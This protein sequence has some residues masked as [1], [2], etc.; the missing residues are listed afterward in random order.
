[1]KGLI[2]HSAFFKADSKINKLIEVLKNVEGSSIIY[3]RTRKTTKQV[4][5]LLALQNIPA[6]FYNAGLLQEERNAR[7]DA[8]TNNSTRVMVCTNAFGMGIDK[9][10]V[11]TVIHYDVPDCL[12]NYYQEAG[13]AGR[14]GKKAYA[15]LIYHI[16]D[17][18]WMNGL[19]DVRFPSVYNI[20]K[21]YQSL[22]DFLQ[23]PV[24]IGDGNYYDFDL[25]EFAGNFNIDI[26]L[27]INVLKVLEQEGHLTFTE[28]IFLPSQVNF[29]APKMLL[30]DL[31]QSHPALEPV[32]KCL[33]RTYEGIYDNRVSINEKLIAKLTR[34]T[35]DS[36]R[37][38]LQQL[39]ALHIID[40]LPQKE[41]PQI[42]FLLN[43][44]PAEFL[45]IDNKAYQLR[46]QQ[47]EAR[48]NAMLVYMQSQSLCRSKYL[49][50]YFGD[51]DIQDCGIC[52]NCLT[53]K[54]KSL[55]A[56]EFGS[57]RDKIMAGIIKENM[58]VKELL[59]QLTDVDKE[60][61]WQVLE[62][63]QSERKIMIDGIGRVT[64][65]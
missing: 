46:K 55:S 52:D 40:Y 56:K 12:E 14:D 63:L 6:D 53:Q 24:G 49:G 44:A 37:N 38:S 8:W 48:V 59:R 57:I 31:E 42:H 29:I 28:N 30:D 54:N 51:A 36:V 21:V 20:K 5:Q 39:K 60:K 1:L 65:K 15:V 61:F 18:D 25:G 35:I 33:L 32:I 16:E 43:R 9:P 41:T 11:R 62:H 17:V 22:A 23:I 13:R 2:Y 3:C 47:F 7:Q 50:N 4:S 58:P 19:A 27:A 10:D 45:Y 64:K 26:Q 34:T